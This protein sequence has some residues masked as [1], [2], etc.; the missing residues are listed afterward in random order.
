[1]TVLHI[2]GTL[3]QMINCCDWQVTVSLFFLCITKV[4][5]LVH[6]SRVKAKY[7]TLNHFRKKKLSPTDKVWDNLMFKRVFVCQGGL[8]AGSAYRGICIQGVGQ[9]SPPPRTTKA[10]GTNP[11]GML[12]CFL[13]VLN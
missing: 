4:T 1:M 6:R 10:G 8:P 2:G 9:T 7:M 12:S 3:C 11:T 5:R 13:S